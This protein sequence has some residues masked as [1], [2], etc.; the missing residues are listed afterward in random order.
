[1]F[2]GSLLFVVWFLRQ[3]LLATAQTT[4]ATCDVAHNWAFNSQKQSPCQ[5]ASSLL[6]VCDGVYEVAALPPNFHYEGPDTQ[7]ATPCQCNTVVYSLLAE[8]GLCQER[9]ISMWSLWETNCATVSIS[10]FP[11]PLPAGLH[12]PG[13]AY[14]DVETSD[15]FNETLAFADAIYGNSSANNSSANSNLFYERTDVL[16]FVGTCRANNRRIG[17]FCFPTSEPKAK[18]C[19][20]RGHRRRACRTP[21]D[22]RS[23]VLGLSSAEDCST[24][25]AVLNSP[26]MSEY[27]TDTLPSPPT[28]PVPS[29]TVSSLNSQPSAS[30]HS[31]V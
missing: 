19:Y 18:Q 9:T 14:Q 3:N 10:S 26:V 2:A 25:W 12:V 29:I 17:H 4:N 22:F 13:W 11:K 23:L 21:I 5:V 6:A 28:M 24:E 16:H 31:V 30:I 7:D 27:R 8:C 20:R 1:M 15:M